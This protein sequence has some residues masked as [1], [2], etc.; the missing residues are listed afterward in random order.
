M[1]GWCKRQPDTWGLGQSRRLT[2]S[3]RIQRISGSDALGHLQEAG[4]VR[5]YFQLPY[6]CGRISELKGRSFRFADEVGDISQPG[7]P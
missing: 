3:C 2:Q 1:I 6:F 7:K 4:Y 5:S